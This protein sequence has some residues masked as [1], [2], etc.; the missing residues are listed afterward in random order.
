MSVRIGTMQELTGIGY[1]ILVDE[2]TRNIALARFY[3][4]KLITKAPQ[5]SIEEA[6]AVTLIL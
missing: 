1:E 3:N 6:S 5:I 4:G 2:P